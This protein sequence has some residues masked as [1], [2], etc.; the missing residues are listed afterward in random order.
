[1]GRTE[2]WNRI[3]WNK[4]PSIFW[5]YISKGVHMQRSQL[6]GFWKNKNYISNGHNKEGGIWKTSEVSIFLFCNL[7][8][9]CNIFLF[10]W[11]SHIDFVTIMKMDTITF[12]TLWFPMQ[13]WTLKKNTQNCPKMNVE[14]ACLIKTISFND[15][16]MYFP[17]SPKE[18]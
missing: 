14:N 1:M 15:F 16:P 7:S 2:L 10:I 5:D 8:S 17:K 6:F 12:F 3:F 4:H 11:I 9:F 13:C 18:C